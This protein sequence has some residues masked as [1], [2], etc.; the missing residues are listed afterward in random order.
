[1]PNNNENQKDPKTDIDTLLTWV[2]RQAD[3][4]EIREEILPQ[5]EEEEA[6]QLAEGE[7]EFLS[8]LL[9]DEFS[10][11]IDFVDT[12]A[13]IQRNVFVTNTEPVGLNRA[14]E[15]DDQTAAVLDE[16]RQRILDQHQQTGHF[17]PG[18][19]EGTVP[20]NIEL[21][22]EKVLKGLEMWKLPIDPRKIAEQ[23]G[24]VILDGDYGD[25]FDARI[26]YISKIQKFAIFHQRVGNGRT[27]G[28]VNFS[29]AHELGHYYLH[30]EYLL[31]GG[32]HNSESDFTSKNT[33]ERQADEFAA[34]L[35][36]P[37]ELFKAKI[38]RLS[39]QI[40]T[41]K[42]V[43]NLSDTAFGTSATSTALRY[44][45]CNFEACA[46]I[47]SRDRKVLW[48]DYSTD[49]QMLNMKFIRFGSPLPSDSWSA[50]VEPTDSGANSE[51]AIDSDIWFEYPRRQELWEEA[52]VLGHTGLV[53]TFLSLPDP[54]LE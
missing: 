3:A 51:G 46:V 48:A 31:G 10:D 25:S 39:R 40:C 54:E 33:M 53:L 37:R 19:D 17:L 15:I 27:L 34:A 30:N 4:N 20:C 44:C 24:I 38:V 22:A 52:M 9:N 42:D 32:S 2:H 35:L 6:K 50:E 41:L 23:E 11:E 12:S 43:C 36:M 18:N 26:E 7:E 49:M 13:P 14:A 28:R 45:K 29:L 1:M 16:N 5:L 47:L 21:E 8:R